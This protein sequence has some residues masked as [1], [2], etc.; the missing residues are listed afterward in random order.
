[1]CSKSFWT[2]CALSGRVTDEAL[3][4]LWGAFP[5]LSIRYV[6]TADP[7]RKAWYKARQNRITHL[8]NCYDL[9]LFDEFNR[10][11]FVAG[12]VQW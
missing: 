5:D 10:I 11:V 4:N 2:N 3:G 1:M 12:V 7:A 6:D 9:I 8:Y